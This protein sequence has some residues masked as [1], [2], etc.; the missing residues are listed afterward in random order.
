MSRQS[1]SIERARKP[2]KCPV[3][4]TVPLASILYGYPNYSSELEQELQ[5]GRTTLGGCCVSEDDA[6]WECPHC[7]QKIYRRKEL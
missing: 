6:A 4:G 1:N 7:G 2:Q 5:E 3:C